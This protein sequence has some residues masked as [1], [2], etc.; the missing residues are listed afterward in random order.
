[1]RALRMPGESGLFKAFVKLFLFRGKPE[2]YQAAIVLFKIKFFVAD[3]ADGWFHLFMV[4]LV[5][6][7]IQRKTGV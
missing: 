6:D 2:I 3:A 1:M 7:Y 4:W 5:S